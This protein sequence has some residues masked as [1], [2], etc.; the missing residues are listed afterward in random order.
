MFEI[1]M[2]SLW[3]HLSVSSYLWVQSFNVDLV[4]NYYV[5]KVVL[6]TGNTVVCQLARYR[7]TKTERRER[8]SASEM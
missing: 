4:S 5:P 2:L 3:V 6:G 8:G 1:K 7:K